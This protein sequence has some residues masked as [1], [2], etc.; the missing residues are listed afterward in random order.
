MPQLLA[1]APCASA[2]VSGAL[3]FDQQSGIPA[4]RATPVPIA[5]FVD[6]EPTVLLALEDAPSPVLLLFEDVSLVEL[7]SV[8]FLSRTMLVLTSQHRLEDVPLG[9]EPVPVP[10]AFAVSAAAMRAAPVI[11]AR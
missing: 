1:V 4:G 9:P 3:F 10:C 5:S 2:S 6:D 7:V 11:I 8:R